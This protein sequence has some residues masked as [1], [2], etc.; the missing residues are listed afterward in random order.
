LLFELASVT[1]HEKLVF[2]SGNVDPEGGLHVG[3][4]TPGQLSDTA[5]LSETA[6]PLGLVHSTVGEGHTM[7]G[8]CMS[9]TVTLPE[10]ESDTFSLSWTVR[11]TELV[12]RE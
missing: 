3:E 1:L 9:F 2:P 11:V 4:P 7:S 5:G 6:A 10:H 12:P 8:G